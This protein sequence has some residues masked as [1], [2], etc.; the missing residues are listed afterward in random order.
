MLDIPENVNFW[1]VPFEGNEKL[2]GADKIFQPLKGLNRN[3]PTPPSPG[4]RQSART[5]IPILVDVFPLMI[6]S[7]MAL[8][9]DDA[10]LASTTMFA[11]KFARVVTYINDPLVN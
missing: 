5:L 2:K 11:G 10:M 1:N 8:T 4:P 9:L 7:G 3:D 6:T